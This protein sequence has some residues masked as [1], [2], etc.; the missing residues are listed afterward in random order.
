MQFSA[1][2]RVFNECSDPKFVAMSGIYRC[3]TFNKMD[4]PVTHLNRSTGLSAELMEMPFVKIRTEHYFMYMIAIMADCF[5]RDGSKAVGVRFATGDFNAS[6]Y[7]VY[8]GLSISVTVLM[9]GHDIYL[10]VRNTSV[11]CDTT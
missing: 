9:M 1:S 7:L 4:M 6:Y 2:D 11:S 10:L 8:M 3:S 5:P